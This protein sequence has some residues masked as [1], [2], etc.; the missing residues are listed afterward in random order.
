MKLSLDLIRT[1][2]GTQPRAE[3]NPA[4]VAEYAEAMSDGAI[5]PPVTVFF[6]GSRYWLADGFHR[7][8]AAIKN[9][10]DEI[11][12]EV[13]Q[14]T[15]RD[16]VLCSLGANAAHGMRRT[17]EDKRRAVERLLNDPEW[18]KWSNYEI[19]K[20][21]AV[22]E[23][24]VRSLRS[25]RSENE[26]R[27]F[28]TKYGT[29]ATMD[30]SHIGKTSK[31][32][33]QPSEPRHFERPHFEPQPQPEFH[34]GHQPAF[35]EKEQEESETVSAPTPHDEA[36][37]DIVRYIDATLDE[38]ESDLVRHSVVTLLIKYLMSKAHIFNRAS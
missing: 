19:A 26:P 38:L 7:F 24:F 36:Y 33:V 17:N 34:K 18:G 14:G 28:T 31:P 29:T 3:I 13:R 20:K 8:H 1:D 15:N 23:Y 6:D 11:D 32:N 10:A 27:T 9:M 12:A 35:E 5:F 22:S 30:T 2:G 16:A 21:A 25:N 37:E 4:M